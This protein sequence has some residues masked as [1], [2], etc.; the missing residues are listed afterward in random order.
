MC[1]YID[2]LSIDVHE[3]YIG[4]E[5]G[6][7]KFA[8]KNKFIYIE[9]YI[10]LK[11]D[12]I[13]LNNRV[14]IRHLWCTSVYGIKILNFILLIHCSFSFD[15]RYSEILSLKWLITNGCWPLTWW[16]IT[17][18]D[19]LVCAMFRIS[20]LFLSSSSAESSLIT[21]HWFYLSNFIIFGVEIIF[22]YQDETVQQLVRK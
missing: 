13:M 15:L 4:L 19:E 6:K 7:T 1:V 18:Q 9:L 21:W 17:C 3:K 12:I 22:S 14:Y 20:N 8:V 5:E 2:P 11:I 10:D 16:L